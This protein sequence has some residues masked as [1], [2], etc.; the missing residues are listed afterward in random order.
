MAGDPKDSIKIGKMDKAEHA[1]VKWL[2][3][4]EG[5]DPALLDVDRLGEK[6]VIS[7]EEAVAY[8]LEG[9]DWQKYL[10]RLEKIKPSIRHP[11]DPRGILP[12]VRERISD[13]AYEARFKTEVLDGFVP[14]S[15]IYCE[16]LLDNFFELGRSTFAEGGLCFAYAPQDSL[17]GL[18]DHEMTAAES[19]ENCAQST[20]DKPKHKGT[21]SEHTYTKMV[22]GEL[23]IPECPLDLIQTQNH[24]YPACDGIPF[25]SSEIGEIGWKKAANAAGMYIAGI[26]KG[27]A[28]NSR[29]ASLINPSTQF[30][31]FAYANYILAGQFDRALACFDDVVNGTPLSIDPFLMI[32]Q[33]TFNGEPAK[34]EELAFEVLRRWPDNPYTLW[35]A[36]ILLFLNGN[37]SEPYVEHLTGR[38]DKEF[39]QKNWGKVVRSSYLIQSQKYDEAEKVLAEALSK[40]PNDVFALS[41]MANIN[42]MK[43]DLNGAEALATRVGDVAPNLPGA[44]YM[45]AS[46]HMMKGR[47]AP[48]L[49]EAKE[50][51]TVVVGSISSSF[52][53][54]NIALQMGRPSD[55]LTALEQLLFAIKD[56]PNNGQTVTGI[57]IFMAQALLMEGLPS[58]AKKMMAMAMELGAKAGIEEL[59]AGIALFEKDFAFAEKMIRII[60]SDMSRKMMEANLLLMK[61]DIE[62]AEAKLKELEGAVKGGDF[63]ALRA[64]LLM[65]KGRFAEA[66]RMFEERLRD[67]EYSFDAA[68]GMA[69][70]DIVSGDVES[71]WNLIEALDISCP[72]LYYRL[73]LIPMNLLR[74]KK[75]GEAIAQANELLK[76][77]PT[78][79]MAYWVKAF[80]YLEMGNYDDAIAEIAA[81]DEIYPYDK[82]TFYYVLAKAHL[83]MG[84]YDTAL[85]FAHLAQENWKGDA[86]NWPLED[87][88]MLPEIIESQRTSDGR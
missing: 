88:P 66:R 87:L 17:M 39:P 83:G 56:H 2:I 73:P 78:E 52:L 23:E 71:A 68:I 1:F 63:R 58:E 61:Y 77:N 31:A 29:I 40:N 54:A 69:N 60:P 6:G 53:Q 4:D 37:M 51:N 10:P 59:A 33:M 45:L 34:A 28:F 62:G 81:Y 72:D 19:F 79:A 12:E 80:S 64:Y 74:E 22:A 84:E 9:D 65:Q 3:E 70:C 8:C 13:L 24:V 46:I 11:L 82:A 30:D 20:P 26:G 67:N 86:Y 36:M 85:E 18:E 48:A 55:A 41:N 7:F 32:G 38:L 76:L 27:G 15:P 14:D 35:P 21:C 44:H 57:A 50:E 5:V 49:E 47:M 42:F 43:G 16:V 75:Y 25:D